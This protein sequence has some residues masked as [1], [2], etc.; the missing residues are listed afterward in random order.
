MK[1]LRARELLWMTLPVILIGGA[2]FIKWNG[3]LGQF[4]EKL[5]SGPARLV[6]AQVKPVA[7]S[8]REVGNG[9]DWAGEITVY[10]AGQLPLGLPANAKNFDFMN[11]TNKVEIV[12]QRDG[13]WRKAPPLGAGK[14]RISKSLLES[15]HYD[16]FHLRRTIRFDLDLDGLEEARQIRLRGEWSVINAYSKEVCAGIAA[17]PGWDKG[18][19]SCS[20][21]VTAPFDILIKGAGDPFPQPTAPNIKRFELLD[22]ALIR[23]GWKQEQSVYLRMRPL[24]AF[25]E[26]GKVKVRVGNPKLRDAKGQEIDWQYNLPGGGYGI[27]FQGGSADDHWLS[28]KFAADEILVQVTGGGVEPKGGWASVAKP[29][30]LEGTLSDG[31]S[32][33]QPFKVQI[34]LFRDELDKFTGNPKSAT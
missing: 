19:I 26:R 31:E 34:P 18:P 12:Y 33:P 24:F 5:K 13:Q 29:M 6:T 14:Y 25:D 10:Q 7:L 2:A 21:D 32:W 8:P 30:T 28:D 20:Y 17:T 16:A 4:P 27:P 15:R 3:L 9:T 23:T 1:P 22:G 11:A